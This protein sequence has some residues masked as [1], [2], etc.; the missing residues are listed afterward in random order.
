[1]VALKNMN[2][3]NIGDVMVTDFG[4]TMTLPTFYK[5]VKRTPQSIK[6]VRLEA[7]IVDGDGFTGHTIPTETKND[8][9]YKG[10]LTARIKGGAEHEYGWLAKERLYFTKWEGKPEYYNH[11]D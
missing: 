10:T 11:L 5:V 8:E 3:I 4:A 1:M 7:Q 6:M 9:G 2:T